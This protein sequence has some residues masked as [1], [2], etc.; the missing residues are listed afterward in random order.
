MQRRLK[1]I[2]SEGHHSASHVYKL[3]HN[4]GPHKLN[5]NAHRFS[6]AVM[7]KIKEDLKYF[8]YF[9]G[10]TSHP[11]LK[12]EFAFF[13]FENPSEEDLKNYEGFKEFNKEQ[14]KY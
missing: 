12:N 8:L 1:D 6:E 3:K 13:D 4:D 11:T 2:V 5:R 10:Y 7:K 14:I 9:F